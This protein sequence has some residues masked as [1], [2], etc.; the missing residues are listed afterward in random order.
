MEIRLARRDEDKACNDFHNRIYGDNRTLEQ[1]QWGYFLEAFQTDKIPFAVVEDKGKIV[2]TQAFIPIRLINKDGIFWTA[3]SEDTLVDPDYRGQKLFE[4]MYDLLFT[5]LD[6]NDLHCIWGFTPAT[7]SFIRLGFEI[8]G[9]ISQLFMP[10]S[11]DAIIRAIRSQL[12]SPKSKP[13]SLL[14]RTSYKAATVAGRVVSCLK[15]S[16][17]ES[18]LK[19]KS[20]LDKI[21]I[22]ITDTAPAQAGELC[23]AFIKKYGGITIYR[24]AA[25]IKWRLLDNPFIKSIIKTA[26]VDGELVGWIAYTHAPDGMGYVIDWIAAHKDDAIVHDTLLLL[27]K[28]AVTD[29]RQTGAVGLRFW[30]ATTHPFDELAS[31]IAKKSGFF[32]IKRGYTTVLY[33]NENSDRK[34]QLSDYQN[35]FINRTFTQ[36]CYG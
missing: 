16:G 17:I 2:G 7:K 29:M 22:T 3:K 33:I 26:H 9:T 18:K 21:N 6:E 30:K 34:N 31:D 24:D 28:E 10:F 8:P 32:H 25:F 27:L 35:W 19:N 15:F 4:K 5:Y 20:N 12:P 23:Q 14:K 11:N 1:W 13:L 36:G